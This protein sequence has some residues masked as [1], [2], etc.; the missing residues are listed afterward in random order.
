[1]P[2]RGRAAVLGLAVMLLPA[3]A[4]AA[5]EKF[6]LANI[7]DSVVGNVRVTR[8]G[9]QDTLLDIARRNGLGYYDI[10]LVNPGVDMWMPDPEAEILLPH[11]YVLPHAPR[12][13][14]VINIPEMRLFY[15]TGGKGA[16]PLSVM[17][18]PIGIGREGRSTPYISTRVIQKQVRPTWYPPESI[19]AEHAAEGRLL[20][21]RVPPGPDN[22]LGEFALRINPPQYL[23]H[24]TNRP[25]GV[26]MRVSGGCIRLYPEDIEYLYSMVE[27][28]TPVH[29]V[30]QPYKVGQREGNLYLQAFPFLEEDADKFDDNL[31]SVVRM[32]VAM[33]ESRA[34]ELDWD[35]ARQTIRQARGVPVRIGRFLDAPP[36]VLAHGAEASSADRQ[37]QSLDLRLETD[38]SARSR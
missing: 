24:G 17:A 19:R 22:P 25:W 4:L 30:N 1:M 14:I 15:F 31:T 3:A 23:I 5:A 10:K 37:M 33:T 9:P 26:G 38:L 18:F 13:G 8:A 12:K 35:L 27:V 2:V 28:G 32:V 34:Y 20:P 21:P 16:A 29:I 36:P 7:E 6:E 11:E